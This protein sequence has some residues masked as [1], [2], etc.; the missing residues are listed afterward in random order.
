M[1]HNRTV[2]LQ[3]HYLPYLYFQG[4]QWL[5]YDSVRQMFPK[6]CDY[7][8]HLSLLHHYTELLRVYNASNASI[9]LYLYY[10]LSFYG[11]FACHICFSPVSLWLLTCYSVPSTF[12]LVPRTMATGH[13]L[14]VPRNA[15]RPILDA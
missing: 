6:N 2:L 7:L 9:I 5:Q 4:Y 12:S 15:S 13:A 8:Y 11:F 3:I 1:R 14:V 10:R